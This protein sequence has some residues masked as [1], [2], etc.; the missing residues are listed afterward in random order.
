MCD[1]KDNNNTKKKVNVWNQ[2]ASD[3]P[4]NFKFNY[5]TNRNLIIS[6]LSFTPG[7][8]FSKPAMETPE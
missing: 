3:I 1:L 6:P 2:N 4:K 8:T 7:F 5:K